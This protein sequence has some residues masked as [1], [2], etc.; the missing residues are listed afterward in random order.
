MEACGLGHALLAANDQMIP[1]ASPGN[2]PKPSG[3]PADP[4][5]ET[6]MVSL[7]ATRSALGPVVDAF[8]RRRQADDAA[9]LLLD[10]LDALFK[11]LGRTYLP[12]SEGGQR[13]NLERVYNAVRLAAFALSRLTGSALSNAELADM[14]DDLLR[15]WRVLEDILPSSEGE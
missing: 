7:D 5:L 15:L 4:G 10:R 1:T 14:H 6:L 13:V 9:G 11:L 3:I 12:Q 8:L 2:L